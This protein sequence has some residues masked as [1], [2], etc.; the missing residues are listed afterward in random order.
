[1]PAK[2]SSY[3]FP[4]CTHAGDMPRDKSRHVGKTLYHYVRTGFKNEQKLWLRK[5]KKKRQAFS[6][7]YNIMK[8]SAALL[9]TTGGPQ[10]SGKGKLNVLMGFGTFTRREGG[11][12]RRHLRVG[13]DG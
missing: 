4:P 6:K 9:E 2:T 7:V 3:C 13:G 8:N 11:S 12:F 10:S 5:E 1:M